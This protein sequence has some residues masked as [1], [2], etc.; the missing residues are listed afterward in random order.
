MRLLEFDVWYRPKSSA[1]EMTASLTDG[2]VKPWA[3]S[4][5]E[6]FIPFRME[7]P[8]SS[9]KR[10]ISPLLEK[11]RWISQSSAFHSASCLVKAW[12]LFCW[13]TKS[14]A[15]KAPRGE[16][17]MDVLASGSLVIWRW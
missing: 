4:P 12:R 7:S 17:W 6:V 9:V 14:P 13:R 8:M 15:S 5:M 2:M 1:D 11:M 3:S 10:S 16:G